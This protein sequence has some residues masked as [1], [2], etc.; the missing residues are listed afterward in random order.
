MTLD[1]SD[2]SPPKSEPKE[3]SAD[4]YWPNFSSIALNI[5]S[6]RFGA[7]P[8][9]TRPD[10]VM[11]YP[12]A[13]LLIQD[14]GQLYEHPK[15]GQQVAMPQLALLGPTSTGHIWETAPHTLFML[16]NLAP[17]ATQSLF[18]IDPRDVREQVVPLTQ[19]D[20]PGT[21]FRLSAN[22]PVALHNYLSRLVQVSGSNEQALHR[23]HQAVMT[24]TRGDFG[25]RVRD[26]AENFGTTTRTLQRT[27]GKAVGLTPKQVLA[28]QR[29]RRLITLTSEGWNRSIADLAQ[30][31]GF[32][33]Q[34][35]LRYDLQRLGLGHVDHFLRGDH[36]RVQ[37]KENSE[38]PHNQQSA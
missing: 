22:C 14:R 33:D 10:R 7:S 6:Y 3:R 36:I 26:Y 1:R 34:S 13:A 8:N 17:G 23:A 28:I 31:G 15:P 24:I 5:I 29:V 9:A 25:P 11:R 21:F 35:H 20:F 30:E 18:G 2:Y 4:I 19:Q 37:N 38:D 12:T 32:Y 16:V 27:V